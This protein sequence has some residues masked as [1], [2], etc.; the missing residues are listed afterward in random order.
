MVAPLMY[1]HEPVHM[2]NVPAGG[3]ECPEGRAAEEAVEAAYEGVVANSPALRTA[4]APF[5]T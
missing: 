1:C 2:K 3:K 5:A 4:A